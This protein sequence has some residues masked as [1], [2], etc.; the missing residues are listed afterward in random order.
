[1]SPTSQQA[2]REEACQ[3]SCS[4]DWSAEPVPEYP[5]ASYYRHT[6]ATLMLDNG[7]DVRYIQEMLGHADLQST[8]IYTQVSI[9][10]LKRIHEATHPGAMLEKKKPASTNVVT[11]DEESLRADLLATLDAEAQ[12]ESE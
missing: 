2:S 9:G 3:T 11:Q 5:Q 12:E 10:R 6:M 1:M 8:Q 4:V 7:A